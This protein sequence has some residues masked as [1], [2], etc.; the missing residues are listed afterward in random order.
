MYNYRRILQ[1]TTWP[2]WW[3]LGCVYISDA[4][5]YKI[6]NTQ[7]KIVTGFPLIGQCYIHFCIVKTY[8]LA[9]MIEHQFL[10]L[11]VHVECT[12]LNFGSKNT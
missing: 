1:T 11:Y 7:Y 2:K 8:Y 4:T 6:S 5:Y 12:I 3:R 9:D 10:I